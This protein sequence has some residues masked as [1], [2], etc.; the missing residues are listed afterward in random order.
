M[1]APLDLMKGVKIIR[2]SNWDAMLKFY[3]TLCAGHEQE[4]NGHTDSS[5]VFRYRDGT[6]LHLERVESKD[7]HE[8]TAELRLPSSDPDGF[9][10][11]LAARGLTV[12]KRSGTHPEFVLT[13]P[14]GHPVTVYKCG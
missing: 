1:D 7:E 5:R 8:V 13:D 10:S 2:T 11:F 3:C 12:E 4:E 6:E 9:A 14:D